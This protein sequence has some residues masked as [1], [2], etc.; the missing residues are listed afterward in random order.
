MNGNVS[1]FH[2]GAN[3]NSYPSILG[4]LEGNSG[5]LGGCLGHLGMKLSHHV[6]PCGRNSKLMMAY[7]PGCQ[8]PHGVPPRRIPPSAVP[9]EGMA[10]FYCP[11]QCTSKRGSQSVSESGKQSVRQSVRQAGRQTETPSFDFFFS[12]AG[13]AS[14]SGEDTDCQNK[15]QSTGNAAGRRLE[16]RRFHSRSAYCRLRQRGCRP[17]IEPL[18]CP[19]AAGCIDFDQCFF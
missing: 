1:S 7:K 15:P 8:P 5:D 2:G 9:C 6:Q 18:T 14:C 16:S 4:Q 13:L 11:R 12:V 17:E 10:K 19:S 3:S